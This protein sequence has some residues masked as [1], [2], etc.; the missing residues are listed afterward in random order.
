MGLLNTYTEITAPEDSKSLLQAAKNQYGFIPNL[1]GIMSESTELLQA[2]L[3]LSTLFSQTTLSAVEKNI[4]LLSVSRAN[5]CDYCMSAH[6]KIALGEGVS[7]EVIDA[8][9]DSKSLEDKK[10][11]A[12]HAFT[13]SVVITRGF[14]GDDMVRNSLK[15]GYT[16]KNILEVMLGIGLKTLSN[17]TNHM[18]HT[19]IDTQFK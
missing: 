10:L 15:N 12:L 11:E 2:Y 4:V 1:L 9:F 8:I 3:N 5:N 13:C 18:A 16:T 6:S 7:N 17:Y 14:P 19:T